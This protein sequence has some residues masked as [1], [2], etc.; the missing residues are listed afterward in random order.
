[1]NP[2]FFGDS[3]R[4]LFGVYTQGRGRNPNTRAVLLCYPV[5]VEYMRA[6]RAFRQ[7]TNLLNR[8]GFDVLRF[9]YSATGDSGGMGTDASVQ[10]WLEDVE[11]AIDELMD[12]AG[13]EEISMVGL[14]FGATLA[15]LASAGRPEVEQLVLWDPI[16]SGRDY[17]DGALGTDRPADVV[18]SDGYPVTPA[19]QREVDAVDLLRLESTG[20]TEINILAGDDRPEFRSLL[21]RAKSFCG[22]VDLEIVPFSGDWAEPDPFGAALIPDRIVQAVVHRLQTLE[23][24]P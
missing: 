3:S 14:R 18:S 12:T 20:A 2:F 8:A 9:D 11:W 21:A 22:R 13:V 15:A 10:A 5:L 7:L 23:M 16:V 1:M 24:L 4:P 6:H 17:L 19:L